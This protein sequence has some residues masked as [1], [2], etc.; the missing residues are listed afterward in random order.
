MLPLQ[1]G[2]IYSAATLTLIACAGEDPFHGLPGAS[3]RR[4]IVDRHQIRPQS[5]WDFPSHLFANPASGALRRGSTDD[6]YSSTWASRAWTFQEAYLAKTRL[7]FT[8]TE[9][10]YICEIDVQVEFPPE[11]FLPRHMRHDLGVMA[12]TLPRNNLRLGAAMP[13]L[14][15]YTRRQL[16]FESDALNAIVGALNTLVAEDPP[17]RHI[18]LSLALI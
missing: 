15:E 12:R 16:T 13:M 11:T 7:Y 9:V 17:V 3:A 2:A 4:L 14:E 18:F 5:S 6:V 8:E 10:I 1:M